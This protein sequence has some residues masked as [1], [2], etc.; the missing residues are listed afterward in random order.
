MTERG[1]DT[2]SEG[3]GKGGGDVFNVFFAMFRSTLSPPGARPGEK[4]KKQ[5]CLC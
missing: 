5:D 2:A 3:G 4:V 1:Y